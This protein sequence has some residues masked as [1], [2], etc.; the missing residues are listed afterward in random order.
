MKLEAFRQKLQAEFLDFKQ[1][2]VFQA[3]QLCGQVAVVMMVMCGAQ[4]G[5]PPKEFG[6]E[7]VDERLC[8]W[9]GG[10]VHGL[11]WVGL[12]G[13][14]RA[15]GE[16]GGREGGCH[17]GGVRGEKELKGGGHIRKIA[18]ASPWAGI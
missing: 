13:G 8:F 1:D 16:G 10:W 2:K 18:A 5:F 7:V 9:W 6:S 14:V 15:A 11:S 3:E 4:D 17:V 12:G